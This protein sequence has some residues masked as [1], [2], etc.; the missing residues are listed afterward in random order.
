M[1]QK[2][3][4]VLTFS[5]IENLKIIPEETRPRPDLRL[6]PAASQ[7]STNDKKL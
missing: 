1:L 4:R 3:N 7:P 2:V 5:K 6:A